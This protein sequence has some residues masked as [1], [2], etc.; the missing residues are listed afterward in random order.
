MEGYD[1]KDASITSPQIG[2]VFTYGNLAWLGRVDASKEEAV[3]RPQAS[4]S[5]FLP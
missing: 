2:K 4:S 5:E 1:T 3:R